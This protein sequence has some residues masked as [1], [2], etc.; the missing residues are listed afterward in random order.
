[1]LLRAVKDWS[2]DLLRS[3]LLADRATDI[4]AALA[5][6]APHRFLFRS[7]DPPEDAIAIDEFDQVIQRTPVASL[8]GGILQQPIQL[9]ADRGLSATAAALVPWVG[10][11]Q[12]P[13]AAPIQPSGVRSPGGSVGSS[14]GW[15][16][17][18]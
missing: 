16:S 1:M 12:S 15:H 14:P 10:Q 9:P 17:A 13:A 3:V 2:L 8:V 5:A 4:R 18:P 6:G 7:N 11:P